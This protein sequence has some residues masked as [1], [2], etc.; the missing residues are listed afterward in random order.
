MNGPAGSYRELL[1]TPI[2]SDGA[3]LCVI[4]RHYIKSDSEAIVIQGN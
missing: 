4:S 1:L 2:F 3:N